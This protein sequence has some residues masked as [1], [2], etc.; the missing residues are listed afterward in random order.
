[1]T[2]S[3]RHRFVPEADAG[4]VMCSATIEDCT[5]LFFGC[6]LVQP[7]WIAVALGGIDTTSVAAFWRS[8]CQGPFRREAEWMTIFATLWAIWLHRNEI[9]F[10]GHLPSTDAVQYDARW[11][12]QSWHLGGTTQ[13]V[14]DPY[15]QSFLQ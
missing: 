11:I 4:C 6:P 2:R 9:I 10:R 13:A 1:M 14:T 12:A 15:Y 7:M 3:L 8:I 5:H